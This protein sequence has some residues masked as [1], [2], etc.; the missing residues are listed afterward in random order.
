MKIAVMETGAG[1]ALDDKK[2]PFAAFS[3][4]D[5]S[6]VRKDGCTW[7]WLAISKLLVEVM[8][9]EVGLDSTPGQGSRF[10]FT[11]RVGVTAG[12]E[13]IRSAEWASGRRALVVENSRSWRDVVV[14][15]LV[16]WGFDAESATSGRD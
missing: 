5:G 3:Q 14:E 4:V 16:A 9:G 8:G 6:L 7:L 2:K 12:G 13:Q 11:I 15:H 1:I 10:W